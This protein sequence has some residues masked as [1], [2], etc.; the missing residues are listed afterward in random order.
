MACW[1]LTRNCNTI[2]KHL[3]LMR[4]LLQLLHADLGLQSLSSMSPQRWRCRL[5]ESAIIRR[6]RHRV[7]K[8]LHK[9][10]ALVLFAAQLDHDVEAAR[11]AL[12]WHP[13]GGALLAVSGQENDLVLL[14]RL[15]WKPTSYLTG[16]HS[17]HITAVAFTEWWVVIPAAAAAKREL[18]GGCRGLHDSTGEEFKPCCGW[19]F[20]PG[21]AAGRFCAPNVS[22]GLCPGAGIRC[23][24]C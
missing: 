3:V 11:Q 6:S 2:T 5:H 4:S 8:L 13:D 24:Y 9:P 23:R 10:A 19:R 12:A 7:I 18:P 1:W 14:E 16:G 22:L 20:L 21:A 17:D 15:S